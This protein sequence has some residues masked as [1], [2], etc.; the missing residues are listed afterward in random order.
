MS[1]IIFCIRVNKIRNFIAYLSTIIIMAAVGVF[2]FFWVKNGSQIMQLSIGE[3]TEA[4]DKL[5]LIAELILMVVVTILCFKYKKYWISL[6]S[7]V[8]TL[9]IAY[10]E[11]FLKMRQTQI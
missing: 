9:L 6:L 8:P 2:T 5:I 4:V 10:F 7:I 3:I 11:L 1:L